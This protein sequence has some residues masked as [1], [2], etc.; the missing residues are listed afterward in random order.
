MFRN[1]D[2]SAL[3]LALRLLAVLKVE[4]YTWYIIC[5]C[6]N[7]LFLYE[8][9][10]Q[11]ICIAPPYSFKNPALNTAISRALADRDDGAYLLLYHN[12]YAI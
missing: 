10:A 2:L 12:T 5:I 1:G 8:Y 9:L 3:I 4:K 6:I 7:T 11:C